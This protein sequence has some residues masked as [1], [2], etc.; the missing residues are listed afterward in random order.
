MMADYVG[1]FPVSQCCM[2]NFGDAV[3]L[4]LENRTVTVRWGGDGR[5]AAVAQLNESVE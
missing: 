2:S 1:G 3:A 4:P 5:M